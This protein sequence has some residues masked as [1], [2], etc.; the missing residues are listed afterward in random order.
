MTA[1]RPDALIVF[2]D[3][4]TLAHRKRIADFAA[5]SRLPMIAELKEFAEADSLKTY[6][7]SRLD[8]RWRAATC[9]D[10]ILKGAKPADL[11]VE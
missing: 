3:G 8:L 11:P 5:K 10:K 6:G 4:L 2:V 9:V 7:T 1:E